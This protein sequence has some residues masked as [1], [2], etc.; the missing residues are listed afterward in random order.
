MNLIGIKDQAE[1]FILIHLQKAVLDNEYDY[2]TFGKIAEP[3]VARIIKKYFI[4]RH[5][6]SEED[7]YESP[8]KNIFPDLRYKNIAIE[9]K[10]AISDDAPGNDMGT[11]N[12]W[13]KKIT[14]YNDNIYYPELFITD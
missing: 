7:F 6:C 2:S 4:E 13:P 5:K 1:Y 8:N 14:T 9:F 10:C 3:L 11:L 12:S